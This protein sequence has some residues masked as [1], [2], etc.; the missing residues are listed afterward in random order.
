MPL[1]RAPSKKLHPVLVSGDRSLLQPPSNSR[2]LCHQ[3]MR[4]T[5][6]LQLRQNST[7]RRYRRHH[8]G[9]CL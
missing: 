4:R 6:A 9:G 2:I 1:S 7:G 8:S 3:T 5:Q